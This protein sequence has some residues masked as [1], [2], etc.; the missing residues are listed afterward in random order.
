[1]SFLSTAV[2]IA[3]VANVILA[4][5]IQTIGGS[6]PYI[7]FDAA[8]D[9]TFNL[10]TV[11]NP[12]TPINF[13]WSDIA[14]QNISS[15]MGTDRKT[16]FLTHGWDSDPSWDHPLVRDAYLRCGDFNVITVD[17]SIV[18]RT[19]YAHAR[20]RVDEIGDVIADVINYFAIQNVLDTTETYIIG[21]SMGAHISGRAGRSLG[22]VGGVPRLGAI[23]GLDTAWPA[24]LIGVGDYGPLNKDDARH[25]QHIKT[26]GLA[27][28]LPLGHANFFVNYG[29]NQPSCAIPPLNIAYDTGCSHGTSIKYFAESITK[30]VYAKNCTMDKINGQKLL[31]LCDVPNA[32]LN[33]MG[34][35]PL[36]FTADGE[37]WLDAGSIKDGPYF[38]GVSRC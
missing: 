9:V 23:V 19:D 31:N 7:N 10:Y 14:T 36:D 8:L 17:W 28:H 24:F 16:R 2:F 11:D 1:M 13:T 26:S 29:Y 25:V 21:H 20:T 12:T 15:V 5:E 3:S 32:T 27:L 4:Q 37:Y 33:L 34:G 30:D 22:G 18:S 38:P 35:E 6:S